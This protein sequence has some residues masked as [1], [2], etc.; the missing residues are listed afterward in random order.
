MLKVYLHVEGL[1]A[2]AS[3]PFHLSS[4][5]LLEANAKLLGLLH[6]AVIELVPRPYAIH[7]PN[8]KPRFRHVTIRIRAGALT[9]LHEQPHTLWIARMVLALSLQR[10]ARGLLRLLVAVFGTSPTPIGARVAIDRALLLWVPRKA[11]VPRGVGEG[12]RAIWPVVPRAVCGMS[13]EV[14]V[15]ATAA[16]NIV[17]ALGVWYSEAVDLA[18]RSYVVLTFLAGAAADRARALVL[19][20]AVQANARWHC[21]GD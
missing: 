20:V 11:R 19:A 7:V 1:V 17:G 16:A 10:F 18:Y 15:E 5:K 9:D 13:W 12:G 8:I 2:Q 14:A 4:R 3:S 6:A 21:G